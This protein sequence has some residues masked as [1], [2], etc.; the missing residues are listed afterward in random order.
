MRFKYF[1]TVNFFLDGGIASMSKIIDASDIE[2]AFE[3]EEARELFE[4]LKEMGVKDCDIKVENLGLKVSD[5]TY[6]KHL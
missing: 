6:S 2:N 4:S 3:C 1:I 5:T